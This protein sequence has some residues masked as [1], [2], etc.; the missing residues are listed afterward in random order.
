MLEESITQ[1]IKIVFN[2]GVLGV[3]AVGLGWLYHRSLAE[4]RTLNSVILELTKTTTQVIEK[5]TAALQNATA[6]Q[7]RASEAHRDI[8]EALR[9]FPDRAGVA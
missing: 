9:R 3:V 8:A 5:N 4:I 2:Y 7:E 1:A 6:A